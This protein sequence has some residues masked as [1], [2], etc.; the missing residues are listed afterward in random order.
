MVSEYQLSLQ[1]VFARG[2][3]FTKWRRRR[4]RRR[5]RRFGISRESHIRKVYRGEEEYFCSPPTHRE[6]Y[7]RFLYM[8]FLLR[9]VFTTITV[10]Q[11]QLGGLWSRAIVAP[12]WMVNCFESE[13]KRIARDTM[14]MTQLWLVAVILIG[15]PF[16]LVGAPQKDRGKFVVQHRFQ[17]YLRMRFLSGERSSGSN[18]FLQLIAHLIQKW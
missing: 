6:G 16:G 10:R 15:L 17:N 8:R 9:V 5:S 12:L 11:S 1:S 13:T 4:R 3:K 2:S 7:T 18:W 14:K